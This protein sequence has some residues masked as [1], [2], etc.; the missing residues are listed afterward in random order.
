MEIIDE[1]KAIEARDDVRHPSHYDLPSGAEAKDV[2]A[3]I[4]TP[5]ELRGYWRG[6]AL[7]YQM[8]YL[9]KN[10]IQDISKAR[11]SLEILEEV[12]G[13]IEMFSAGGAVDVDALIDLAC[14]IDDMASSSCSTM[15]TVRLDAFADI[16][17][18]IREACGVAS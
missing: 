15:L 3:M 16:A 2:L 5:V 13:D 14:E 18:R 12:E 4:L 17:R 9:G 6:C 8:R 7:K 11:R 10:G 1:E